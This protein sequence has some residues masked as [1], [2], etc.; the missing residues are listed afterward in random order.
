MEKIICD[1]DKVTHV[2][3]NGKE[4]ER[5]RTNDNIELPDGKC[6]L[7]GLPLQLGIDKPSAKQLA[8]NPDKQPFKFW[9]RVGSAFGGKPTGTN[10][11]RVDFYP[12]PDGT[13]KST[14]TAFVG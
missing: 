1:L 14:E 12:K 10:A 5:V 9:A 8:K 7:L 6:I 4:L 11:I 3:I 13:T 2:I